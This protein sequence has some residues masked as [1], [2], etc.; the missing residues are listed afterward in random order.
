MVVFKK[1]HVAPK[2][3]EDAA[4]NRLGAVFSFPHSLAKKMLKKDYFGLRGGV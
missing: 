2:K 4:Q 3:E 1:K